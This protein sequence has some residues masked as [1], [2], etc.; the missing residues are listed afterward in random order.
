MEDGD[1]ETAE[2]IARRIKNYEEEQ[3][4]AISRGA[5]N[6]YTDAQR[7]RLHDLAIATGRLAD[8]LREKEEPECIAVNEQALAIYK[9]IEDR[10][11]MAIR[12]LNL[13]HC[14][15]NLEAIRDLTN[16][17]EH[18]QMAFD[19]YPENDSLARA[20]CL[21]QIS[22]ICVDRLEAQ[23]KGNRSLASLRN[24][25]TRRLSNTKQR[26]G[27]CHRMRGVISP[28]S[29][30]SWPTRC[31]S[32]LIGRKMPSI[33]P[34]HLARSQ[35]QLGGTSKL[36]RRDGIWPNCWQLCNGLERRWRRQNR[37]LRNTQQ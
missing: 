20:Q 10:P 21:A 30:T 22:M 25:S 24:S 29:T 4:S 7:K 14:Y 13:G 35:L 3:A 28:I 12:H 31:D 23:A 26:S 17:Q 1:F 15:K 8:V 34:E 33:T 32:I 11:G 37:H 2:P 9:L 36:P 18:Y 27:C 5:G 6:R 16:S 19:N